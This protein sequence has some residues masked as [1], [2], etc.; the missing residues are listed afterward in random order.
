MCIKTQW[1]FMCFI[2]LPPSSPSITTVPNVTNA[3]LG[4]WWLIWF[5]K[6]ACSLP[7][8]YLHSLCQITP[9]AKWGHIFKAV[10]ATFLIVETSNL[11]RETEGRETVLCLTVWGD[12][13]HHDDITILHSQSG[14]RDRDDFWDSIWC[15]SLF[16]SVPDSWLWSGADYI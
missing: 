11:Q 12:K 9:W 3:V 8:M 10:T 14:T 5:P 13:A 4:W 7:S 15:F 6:F 2:L 16:Y 1:S